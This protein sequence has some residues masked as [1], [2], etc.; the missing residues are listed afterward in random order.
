MKASKKSI[1]QFLEPRKMV[2]AGVSRNPK[3]FGYTAFKELRER[4]YEVI[5]VH[6]EAESIDGVVCYR[7]LSDVPS[8]FRHVV[9]MVPKEETMKVVEEAV[10]CGFENIWIQ[11]M[12]ETPEAVEFAMSKNVNLVTGTCILLHSDP[13]KGFHKIHLILLKIFGGMPK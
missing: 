4:G 2:L 12:S 9:T 10:S 6:P 11:Q 1:E 8:S 13:V 3:K 7:N 5:P